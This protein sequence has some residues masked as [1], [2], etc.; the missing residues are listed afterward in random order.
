M[1]SPAL[2]IDKYTI[3]PE[4]SQEHRTLEFKPA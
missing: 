4:Y 1:I 3:G 2:N